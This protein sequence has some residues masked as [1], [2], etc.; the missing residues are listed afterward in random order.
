MK[1]NVFY[2][3]F[4][5]N[6][7]KGKG[8]FRA[9]SLNDYLIKDEQGNRI[10]IPSLNTSGIYVWG[11]LFDIDGNGN[12][13]CPTNCDMDGFKFDS[14]K[15]QFIPYYVGKIESSLFNR[16]TVHSKVTAGNA[17]SYIRFSLSYWKEFFKDPLYDRDSQSLIN[18]VRKINN[19]VVYHNDIKVLQE[20]Y[21]QMNIVAVGNNHPITKQLLNNKP[22]FD[23]LD[24][25][26][27]KLNNFWFCYCPVVK[28]NLSILNVLETQTYYSLKGKTTSKR[29]VGAKACTNLLI[30]DKTNSANIFKKIKNN[31][32]QEFVI[33]S[34]CF[35]GY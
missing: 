8:Q 27:N 17:L 12:I 18:L 7:F 9:N 29:G 4:Q 14:E 16:L 22:I 10:E 28:E 2:G 20:I 5:L 33:P 3:P 32:G 19:S 13:L 34:Q 25:V 35:F 15:H 24:Y 1:T 6:D 23:T 31:N 26:V 11:N 21:P 30:V